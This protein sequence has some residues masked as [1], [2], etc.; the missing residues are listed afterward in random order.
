MFQSPLD[1]RMRVGHGRYIN[2][3]LGEDC[4][5]ASATEENLTTFMNQLNP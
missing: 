2:V 3:R 4:V 1:P 5:G